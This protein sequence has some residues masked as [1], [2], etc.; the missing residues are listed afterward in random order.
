M[1]T[2]WSYDR[3]IDALHHCLD[4]NLLPYTKWLPDKTGFLIP[5]IKSF[6][7][8]EVSIINSYLSSRK[9]TTFHRFKSNL[10]SFKFKRFVNLD[11][12]VG[13]F[14]FYH[15]EFI[16]GTTTHFDMLSTNACYVKKRKMGKRW[17]KIMEAKT[18]E[19]L[20]RSI[21]EAIPFF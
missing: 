10:E 12:T 8:P 17:K 11:E 4:S 14:K 18:R 21:P 2:S 3:V 5:S 1:N 20:Q 9:L 7:N 15:P 6:E 13:G 16:P 19:N